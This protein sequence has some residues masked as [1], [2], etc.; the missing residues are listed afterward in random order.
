MLYTLFLCILFMVKGELTLKEKEKTLCFHNTLLQITSNC[1]SSGKEKL[2]SLVS[3]KQIS[4]RGYVLPAFVYFQKWNK[5]LEYFAHVYA[6]RTYFEDV[7]IPDIEDFRLK[8]NIISITYEVDQY[9][10]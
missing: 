9:E 2:H 4:F 1:I 5:T 8:A 10:G 3:I 6:M 7:T